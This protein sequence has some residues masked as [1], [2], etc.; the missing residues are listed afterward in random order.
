[1][2]VGRNFRIKERGNLQI[3]ADFTN[4]FNRTEVNHPTPTAKPRLDSD[5]L[6]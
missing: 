5:I 3:R 6:T 4:I 1:M 2:S